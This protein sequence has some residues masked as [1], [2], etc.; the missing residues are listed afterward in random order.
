[1]FAPGGPTAAPVDLNGPDVPAADG[2]GQEV[3]FIGLVCCGGVFDARWL[4]RLRAVVDLDVG[5]AELAGGRVV[6][7]P[8]DPAWYRDYLWYEGQL[9][10]G[11]PGEV[12]PEYLVMMGLHRL[13]W[14]TVSEPS[15][16][17]TGLRWPRT[18]RG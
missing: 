11:E 6:L 14:A 13:R 2:V 16:F 4:G 17:R 18:G 9:Q 10:V 5:P 7:E 8:A 12:R 1:M 3:P 15:A